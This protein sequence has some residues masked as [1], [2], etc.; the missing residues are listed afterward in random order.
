M[1]ILILSDRFYPE[2]AAPSVRI[3]DHARFWIEDGHEVTVVTSAPNFPKGEVFDGYRNAVYQEEWVDGIRT[4][5]LWSYM[6]ANEGF[7]KRI[8]DYLSL[9]AMSVLCC[10]R[11]PSFDVV[12]ATSPPLFTAIAGWMVALFRRRPW[13]FEIRDLWPA[14]I[15]A[16]AASDSKLLDLFEQLEL[17]LYRRATRI[18]ALTNSFVED[19]ASRGIDTN[20]I[21]VV[22]NGVDTDKFS[23]DVVK[24]DA[25]AVMG[26]PDAAFLAGYV[27][28]TG[29]AH[30]L[31]TLLDAAELCMREKNGRPIHFLIL[32]EGAERARL[33]ASAAER[34]LGNLSFRDFVAHEHMPDYL[35]ALDAS[36]VHLRPDP[37][38]ETVIPSKIFEAMAM[39]V[40]IVMAV[41]GE[42]AELVRNAGAGECIASGDPAAMARTIRALAN[43]PER[44]RELSEN[45]RIAAGD[46]FSRRANARQ[47]IESL[48][49]A[50]ARKGK[51]GQTSNLG[52]A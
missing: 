11:Y 49:T 36:I 29:M 39:A 26:I 43:D 16:V 51:R 10:F 9:V 31:E 34:G 5:R 50:V 18:V 13:I 21:D 17:F 28:T 40:P 38:F 44:C 22:I 52:G 33:E 12:V 46:R 25:R 24:I 20:K 32:G 37:L 45:G 35:A 7:A 47:M 19:L 4:I 2:I 42:S 48:E 15:R 30:G 1:K 8:L 27:G 3:T 14:S 6:A 41:P 23:R